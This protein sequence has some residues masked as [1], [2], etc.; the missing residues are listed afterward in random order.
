MPCPGACGCHPY[1]CLG[2]TPS[3]TP[4]PHPTHPL[5]QGCLE[6]GILSPAWL[7]LHDICSWAL[8]GGP[9]GSPFFPGG[10]RLSQTLVKDVA[11]LAQEIHDVAGDSDTLASPGPARSP[12]LN[13]VP[14][15][16]ASTISAREEV[17]PAYPHILGQPL[18]P[19][20]RAAS[21]GPH[22]APLCILCPGP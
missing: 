6:R 20:Q 22:H 3:S 21:W 1:A 15:T 8:P 5:S 4:T 9:M 19:G 2:P 14:S 10:C 17:S 18:H 11:I 7:P 16:P 13:N 12:S